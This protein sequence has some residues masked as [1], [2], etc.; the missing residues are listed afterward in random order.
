M[1][2][3]TMVS[4]SIQR[5]QDDSFSDN[6][7]AS[8]SFTDRWLATS[9]R[10]RANILYAPVPMNKALKDS[11]RAEMLG[12]ILAAAMQETGTNGL[13]PTTKLSSVFDSLEYIDFLTV[14]DA[15]LGTANKDAAVNAET[16][17]D[18]AGAYASAG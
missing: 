10:E 15:K 6:S 2:M 11:K 16:F 4:R 1:G 7:S 9:E 13:L 17:S 14:L 12:K 18:L 5:N 3:G 8:K